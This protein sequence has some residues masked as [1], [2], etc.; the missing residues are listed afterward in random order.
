MKTFIGFLSGLFIGLCL[1]GYLMY[2][3]MSNI[4]NQWSDG[5]CWGYSQA[6]FEYRHGTFPIE[7]NKKY[8]E[9]GKCFSMSEEYHNNHKLYYP[10]YRFF[11]WRLG[12]S[13]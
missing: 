12:F 11:R 1:C 2:R 5:Y 3:E 4:G 10:V 6:D 13:T 7:H 9:S 8:L